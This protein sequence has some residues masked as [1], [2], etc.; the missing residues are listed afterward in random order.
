MQSNLSFQGVTRLQSNR[1]LLGGGLHEEDLVFARSKPRFLFL[2]LS[3]LLKKLLQPLLG[4]K[5]LLRFS[6]TASWLLR[7][8][9]FELSCES[10]GNR[11]QQ[12]AL[13][14]SEEDLRQWIPDGGS[15]IDVG[16]GTGRWSRI[17][18][19][20]AGQVVGMD[21]DEAHVKAARSISSDSTIEYVVGD[22]TKDLKDRRFDIGLLIHVIEHME[23]PDSVLRS[24]HKIV[25]TIIVEVP[26]FE[27]D[28][29]N[30]IRLELDCPYYSDADHVREYTLPIL[31]E[32]L[33]RNGWTTCESKHHGGAI[34]IVAK[35]DLTTPT[36]RVQT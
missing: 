22:V 28:C 18:A 6:L 32:Q 23:D 1:F 26:D 10:F 33:R 7:R 4:T 15:V 5:R 35:R 20:Y 34:L 19:R 17:A 16:C 36:C 13:A 30:L 31:K 29:L 21:Y 3:Y 8:F 2:R 24:L 11:F 25:D 12:S 9:A 14:L 27:A